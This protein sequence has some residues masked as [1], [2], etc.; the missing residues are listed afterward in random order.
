MCVCVRARVRHPCVLH[1]CARACLRACLRVR[2]FVRRA[3]VCDHAAGH[4]EGRE[5]LP[6]DRQDG[7][8]PLL[9]PPPPTHTHTHSALRAAAGCR[10]G[11]HWGVH[12]PEGWG[13]GETGAPRAGAAPASLAGGR[14]SQLTTITAP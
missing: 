12:P 8:A 6:V 5:A 11:P 14:A 2:A 4:V 13:W 9:P 7:R 10:L 1:P 3:C